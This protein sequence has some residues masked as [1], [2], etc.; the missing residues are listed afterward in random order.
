VARSSGSTAT[1]AHT[2]Q[3]PAPPAVSLGSE[4]TPSSRVEDR[5]PA[6]SLRSTVDWHRLADSLGVGGIPAQLA[7]NCTLIEHTAGRLVLG[8]D[9]AAEQLRSTGTERRLREALEQ[10]LDGP[11]NLEIRVSRPEHETPA[12]RRVR[13]RAEREQA[14]R[15]SLDEDPVAQRLREQLDAQWVAGS[16]EPTD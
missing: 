12:Q 4:P 5:P 7:H 16:I 9:P 10:A 8:L 11:L 14:A 1:S 3:P 15:D 13:E 2:S 6:A